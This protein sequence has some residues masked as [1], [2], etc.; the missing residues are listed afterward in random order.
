M[1]HEYYLFKLHS[2]EEFSEEDT[3]ESCDFPFIEALAAKGII[4]SE[5]GF[6]STWILDSETGDQHCHII[7]KNG[8]VQFVIM[9]YKY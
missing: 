2:T 6:T 5:S 7:D 1:K 3:E 8:N 9:R 4:A